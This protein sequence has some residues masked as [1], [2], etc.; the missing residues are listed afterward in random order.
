[1]WFCVIMLILTSRLW[2]HDVIFLVDF[3]NGFVEKSYLGKVT[4]GIF[5]ISYRSKV[6]SK[7]V[8]HGSF[9]PLYP[10]RVKNLG[11]YLDSTIS[12]DK[13]VSETWKAC[14]STFV[15]C[16]TLGLLSLLKTEASRT[17][18]AAMVG[19]R[20]DFCNSLLAGTSVSNLARLQL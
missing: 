11:V 3:R 16:V 10:Y 6:I 7:K 17:I 15:H 5:L 19:F 8:S 2:R 4:K 12:F 14:F 1:M 13:Q 18:A 20:L 9:F